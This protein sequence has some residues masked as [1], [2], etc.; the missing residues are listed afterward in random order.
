MGFSA[1]DVAYISALSA[2]AGS[3]IGGLT[4]GFTTW[5]SHRSQVRSSYREHQLVR[6]QDLFR[7]FIVSASKSYGNALIS[8]EPQI[9]E[10]VELYA[11]VSQ[12]R[13]LCSPELV[14]C[15]ETLVQTIGHTYAGPSRSAEEF[16]EIARNPSEEM[17]VI[18][19]FSE[20]ARQELEAFAAPLR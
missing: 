10:F 16:L 14:A 12:M 17:D 5:L 6:R 11:L 2:L 15:A 20:V 8:S 13:V 19:R 7:H 9:V 4:T 3:I 1:M 18:R